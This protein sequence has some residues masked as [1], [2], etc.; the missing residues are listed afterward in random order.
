MMQKIVIGTANFTGEYGFV[1]AK[2]VDSSEIS[3]VIE[4][5]QS[6][7]INHF[8]TAKSYGN[9]EEIL[10]SKL[11]RSKPLIID[12]KIN[13]K[14]CLSVDM[15]VR[16]AR[17][18]IEK[19]GVTKISTLYLHNFEL[20]AADQQNIVKKGLEKVLELELASYIGISVY[21]QSELTNAKKLYPLFTHFQIIEN[22]C[23]RR[24]NSS[25]E[26]I[27]FVESGNFINVRSIFLQGILLSDPKKL[28]DKFKL[29]F[30]AINRLH[31]YA[32]LKKVQKKSTLNIFYN[33]FNIENG[34][35]NNEFNIHLLDKNKYIRK[36]K[37][38][39]V[40]KIDPNIY[41]NNFGDSLYGDVRIVACAYNHFLIKN[42]DVVLVSR[43]F[44][45]RVRAKSL[46]IKAE[47]YEKNRIDLVDLYQGYSVVDNLDAVEDFLTKSFVE[48]ER[49]LSDLINSKAVFSVILSAILLF[50]G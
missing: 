24:L 14:E 30:Y 11:D 46:G 37:N 5:A 7:G 49:L 10:G 29:A 13:K 50:F 47:N 15:I 2:K 38:N 23:D 36:N 6:V 42:N 8:D 44:N 4:H 48:T 39:T 22:I 17:D 40:L 16:A 19:V 1:S 27:E 12:S 18:T 21:T 3:K 34:I 31:Q 35:I 26:I 43:D 28:Q 9:A 45:L 20:I 32:D 41:E 33:Y 25:S